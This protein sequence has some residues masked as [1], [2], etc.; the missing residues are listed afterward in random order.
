ERF[1]R[2]E[3]GIAMIV[4]VVL[5][6]VM[7]TLMALVM[8]ISLHTN[9]STGHGRSAVQALHVGEAGVQDAIAKLQ[10]TDGAYTGT[11]TGST[12][13]GTYNVTVTPQTR[14]RFQIDSVG[15]AGA[16]AGLTATRRL[17]V[18]LAPPPSFLYALFSQT[19]IDTKNNDTIVGDIW[20]NQNVI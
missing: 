10:Q 18:T 12:D 16:G 5:L 13:E 4:A 7:G 19:T 8:T 17:R 11:F 1:H 20:A 3:S 6:A 14:H 2:E 9:F 15:S